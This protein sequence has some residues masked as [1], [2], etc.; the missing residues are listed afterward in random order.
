MIIGTPHDAGDVL[1]QKVTSL[2]EHVGRLAHL[3]HVYGP[4]PVSLLDLLARV[5][6]GFAR[7]PGRGKRHVRTQKRKQ[8]IWCANFYFA[9][10]PACQRGK[11]HRHVGQ[12]H[13]G[14]VVAVAIGLRHEQRQCGSGAPSLAIR[15]FAVRAPAVNPFGV[16]TFGMEGNATSRTG[17][18]VPSPSRG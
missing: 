1:R 18:R 8:L 11:R 4:G 9:K 15:R 17:T 14:H 10:I 2:D 6:G 13:A 5:A 16:R 3:L 12:W 7:N